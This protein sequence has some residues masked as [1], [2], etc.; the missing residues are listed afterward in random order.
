MLCLYKHIPCI[1][2]LE[3]GLEFWKNSFIACF[4][5]VVSKPW[6][7]SLQ[8]SV[9]L[10]NFSLAHSLSPN[11]VKLI[12]F[13]LYVQKTDWEKNAGVI[14]LTKWWWKNPR[15]WNVGVNCHKQHWNPGLETPSPKAIFSSHSRM[16]QGFPT[17]L[18]FWNLDIPS[19]EYTQL[20]RTE[21][22]FERVY[23]SLHSSSKVRLFRYRG[24]NFVKDELWCSGPQNGCSY[25]KN[26]FNKLTKISIPTIPL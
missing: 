1:Y 12:F 19:L 2:L 6:S 4:D 17:A 26:Q 21:I 20:R 15:W 25:G 23:N 5:F 16:F 10:G 14:A 9:V 11:I 24:K 3:F 7:N 22:V 8:V 13:I 18:E